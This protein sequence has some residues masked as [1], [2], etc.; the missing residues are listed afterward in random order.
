M[1]SHKKYSNMFQ[2][3]KVIM[4]YFLI[5]FYEINQKRITERLICIET[6]KPNIHK[7]QDFKPILKRSWANQKN[8]IIKGW[9]YRPREFLKVILFY[10]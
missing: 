7:A 9:N 3:P 5:S 2:V 4:Q 10:H 8:S 6:S 1:V